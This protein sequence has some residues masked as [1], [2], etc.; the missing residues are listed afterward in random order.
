MDVELYSRGS[1]DCGWCGAICIVADD[2]TEASQELIR[3]YI[4][5]VMR[6]FGG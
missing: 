2:N 6:N 1:P 5:A 4:L 3:K